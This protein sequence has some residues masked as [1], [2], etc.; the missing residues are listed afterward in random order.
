MHYKNG[1]I[2]N[3]GDWVVGVSHNSRNKPICGLVMEIMPKQG[4]CNIR[5]HIWKDEHFA[6]QGHPRMIPA[7]ES[8]GQD[9]YGDSKEF[10]RVDDGLKMVKAVMQWGNYN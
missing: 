1:R 5:I 4:P 10:I 6:E 3:I 8:R 7:V 2:V 9:D